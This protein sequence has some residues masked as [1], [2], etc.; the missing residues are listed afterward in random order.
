MNFIFISHSL[1]WAKK[2]FFFFRR[3]CRQF[4]LIRSNVKTK[5]DQFFF[6]S[7]SFTLLVKLL[8]S[9]LSL[10]LFFLLSSLFLILLL[11]W[12]WIF[13]ASLP[14]FL[15]LSLYFS[16]SFLFSLYLSPSYV[17]LFSSYRFI[18]FYLTSSSLLS[19]ILLPSLSFRLLF[20]PYE[21]IYM[22]FFLLSAPV[23]SSLHHFL[24]TFSLSFI[25]L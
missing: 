16:F 20:N 11:P 24:S 2:I 23:T 7:F 12:E 4:P 3:R 8:P 1:N 14:S 25:Y 10:F 17:S 18:S 13:Q 9:S 22:A 15:F 5:V 21:Y 6:L 19:H